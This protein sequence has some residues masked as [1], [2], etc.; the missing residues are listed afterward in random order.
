MPIRAFLQT[1]SPVLD[2]I[3]G[4]MGAYDF[5][6][7][8]GWGLATVIGAKRNSPQYPHW[9]KLLVSHFIRPDHKLLDMGCQTFDMNI[10]MLKR[11]NASFL[12]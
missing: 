8:L 6:P 9:I 7:V 4:P 2:K 11:A 10:S 3:S 1:P 12:Q 5:Y